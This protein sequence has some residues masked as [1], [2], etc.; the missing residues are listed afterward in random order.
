MAKFGLFIVN[1]EL[2]AIQKLALKGAA[3]L[4]LP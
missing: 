4:F 1:V 2:D 3:K